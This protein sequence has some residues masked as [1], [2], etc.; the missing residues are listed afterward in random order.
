MSAI[1]NVHPTGVQTEIGR[2][3]SFSAAVRSARRASNTVQC[4]RKLFITDRP[5]SR[6]SA[7]VPGPS[8]WNRSANYT[9]IDHKSQDARGLCRENVWLVASIFIS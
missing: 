4:L 8:V 2:S 6:S 1:P 5:V 3:K 7:N 9:D